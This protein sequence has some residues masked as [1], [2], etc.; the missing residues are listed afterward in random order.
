MKFSPLNKLEEE[1]GGNFPNFTDLY[2]KGTKEKYSFLYLD[3]EKIIAR[4]NF[5]D[6]LYEKN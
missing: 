6:I 5:K 4:K 1:F 3:Q 2:D